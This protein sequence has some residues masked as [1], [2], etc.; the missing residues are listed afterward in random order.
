MRSIV[1]VAALILASPPFRCSAATLDLQTAK[2]TIDE[3][4]VATLTLA[5]G[6][7]WPTSDQ[8][9]FA[10]QTERGA[11]LPEVVRLSGDKL[12]KLTVQFE[13]AAVAEFSVTTERAVAVFRLTRLSTSEQVKQ[14]RL[15]G[16]PAP[17]SAKVLGTINAAESGA[18]VA[19]VMAAEPNVHAMLGESRCSA[20]D[21]AGCSHEF[22]RTEEA[23]AGR[24]AARF[25]ATCNEEPGGWSVRGKAF[26]RPVDLT[27]C[28][29]IRAWVHGDGKGEA[30]KIQ[31]YDGAAATATTT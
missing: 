21:R 11:M 28:K 30:L 27:G 20:A 22:V 12:D 15:F 7:P 9:V 6:S 31:L 10:L 14:F 3:R 17:G 1:F 29:A 24:G 2:L 5:D 19:A 16:L 18:N 26:P 4:G 25:T 8:P 23:K 13:G